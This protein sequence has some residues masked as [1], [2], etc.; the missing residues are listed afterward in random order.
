MNVRRG[1]R[2]SATGDVTNQIA[3]GYFHGFWRMIELKSR[4]AGD[5]ITAVDD[6]DGQEISPK[7]AETLHDVIRRMYYLK[8]L[9]DVSKEL[10]GT[11]EFQ[12]ILNNFLLMTMGNFGVSEG[13]IL[14]HEV[15]SQRI[16][17]FLAKGFH[18]EE[19]ESLQKMGTEFLRQEVPAPA[20]SSS[21]F[22]PNPIGF[23]PRVACLLCFRL[24]SDRSGLM[25]LGA[26]LTDEPYGNEDKELLV[27]L[28]NNLIVALRNARS[29]EDIKRLNQDLQEKKDQIEKAVVE[30]NK[31]VY[32]LK[33][34]YDVSRDIFGTVDFAVILKNFLLMAMGSFGV[35]EG[36]IL[37]M[38]NASEDIVHFE[39]M[40]YQTN[41]LASLREDT[42][43]LL[44]L[45]RVRDPVGRNENLIHPCEIAPS[46]A[47]A[48]PF[49]VGVHYSGLLGLGSK[50]V[51]EPY[52]EDDK[53][54]LVTLVNNL[55]VSL[56]NAQ[57]F[58][59]IRR[60]NLDLQEKNVEL[61]KALKELQTAM[62]KVELLESIK[63]NLSKFVPT[64]VSRLIEKSPTASIPEAREQDVSVLFL[65][66]EG[67]T[68]ISERLGSA[69]LNELIERYFSVFMDA[70]HANNGDVN[71]TA[72]DGLMVLFMSE[73]QRTNAMNA[74]RAALTIREKAALISQEDSVFTEPLFINMGI[75]SGKA[76]LGAAK[77][78]S[79]TGS[80]WTYTARGMVTNVA[81]RIGALASEGAI[82]LSRST[83]DRVK[84]YFSISPVGRFTLKN[85]SEQVEVFTVK[86]Q[87]PEPPPSPD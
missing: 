26:K 41:D 67:Y 21:K 8:T 59:E 52:S 44:K 15:S 53:E 38:D 1:E 50:L 75:N 66:I 85:V 2:F 72:G 55:A 46:V 47:C 24:D 22:L 28:I 73:D 62:R 7:G 34:L 54:L 13:F 81:A 80:R 76:L 83:S 10:F 77:F 79:Y 32:H 69:E 3:D 49:T 61:E 48:V 20:Q 36:F 14:T 70:I 4:N 82:H 33:T 63:A 9:Y 57:S 37:A 65:D 71:E 56:K 64:T 60:L 39:S 23:H 87:P 27:T 6:T 42:R 30:L 35:I 17:H 31:R 58:E 18:E 51:G 84:E 40:G 25:A 68:K 43:K 16:N 12:T 74:V 11:T 86:G 5:K 29:F 19:H 45:G 78:E